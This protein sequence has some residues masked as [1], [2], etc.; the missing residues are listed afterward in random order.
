MWVMRCGSTLH[1]SSP[2][3]PARTSLEWTQQ[4][5]IS[6]H[7]G[8]LERKEICPQGI[9]GSRQRLPIRKRDNRV[10]CLPLKRIIKGKVMLTERG[11]EDV[12][13]IGYALVRLIVATLVFGRRR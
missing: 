2:N 13:E 10:G 7:L 8:R 11:G 1:D 3:T 6:L 4:I 5:K 12:S 9:F